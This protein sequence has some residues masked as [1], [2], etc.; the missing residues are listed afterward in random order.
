MA[1]TRSLLKGMELTDEQVSTIINEHVATVDAL[2]DQLKEANT[3][4]DVLTKDSE[5]LKLLKPELDELKSGDWQSKYETEHSTFEA[6]KKEV[7]QKETTSKLHE[8]YRKLLREKNVGEKH[9]DSIIK[10]TDFTSMKIDKEGNLVDADK[11]SE[12]ISSEWSGFITTT[13]T[14]GAKVSNPPTNNGNIPT[15]TKEEIIAIKDGEER[16]Q[17]IKEHPELFK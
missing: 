15:V 8:A 12:N 14:K 2:K 11:L 4:I 17:A 1:L 10:V 7:N 3:K 6:Y 13:E 16:R 9:I 5:E